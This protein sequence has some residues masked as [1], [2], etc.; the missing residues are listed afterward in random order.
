MTGIKMKYGVSLLVLSTTLL[1]VSAAQAQDSNFARDRNVAV[2]ERIPV[3]YEPR[4]MRWGTFDVRPTLDVDVTSNDNIYYSSIQKVSDVYSAITPAVRLT[5]DW[6]RHQ[7]TASVQSTVLNY[8]DNDQQNT[9]SWTAALGGRLDIHGRSNFFAGVNYSDAFE[10]LYDPS[11]QTVATNLAKPIEFTASVANAGFVAEGNR[12]RFTGQATVTKTDYKDAVNLLGATIS[13]DYRDY[14]QTVYSGRGDYALSP[15]TA[16]FAV[17]TGNTR[18][19]DDK[20][21]GRD[22]S[23]YD[24]ALGTTFDLTNLIR[25]A[26]QVG[27]QK[28]EYDNPIYNDVDGVSY[29]AALQYFPTQLLTLRAVAASNIRETP[30][31]NA[32]SYTS[33]EMQIG[34]DYELLRTLVL[35][36]TFGYET[37][38]YNGVNRTD[39]RTTFNFGGKYLINRNIFVRA[40][41]TYSEN[42]SK[43]DNAILGYKDNAFNVSLGLQY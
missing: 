15:D 35:N 43:G 36:A 7:L 17:L 30:Q 14:T 22:S 9:T 41:Y 5:S 28:Q 38:G 6:G 33:H 25:G 42:K 40:G 26:V 31:L 13:Q 11:A 19:Y 12:L 3:E 8:A 10:P 37:D 16:V 24:A 1:A 18:D 4:G 29:S 20:A 39:D 32:S 21:I 23:G 34:A 2:G 27:Y